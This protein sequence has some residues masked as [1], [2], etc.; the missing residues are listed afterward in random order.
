MENDSKI[1]LF[2]HRPVPKA[3]ATLAIPTILSGKMYIL[4]SR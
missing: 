4:E 3:I 2:E 1:E